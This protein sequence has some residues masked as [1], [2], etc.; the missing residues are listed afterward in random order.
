M[1]WPGSRVP[2][3]PATIVIASMTTAA[4]RSSVSVVP[5]TR[6]IG[7]SPTGGVSLI[8]AVAILCPIAASAIHAG[9]A[10][11]LGDPR[12]NHPRNRKVTTSVA[13]LAYRYVENGT[14]S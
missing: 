7:R 5:V 13:P 8:G 6:L 3:H 10:N 12:M 1:L 14:G 9:L 2:I 11:R 4:A